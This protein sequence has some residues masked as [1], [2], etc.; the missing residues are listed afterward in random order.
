MRIEVVKGGA[1]DALRAA[2]SFQAEWRLLSDRCI[3]ATPFQSPAF[4]R[5]WYHIYRLRFE[6]V[7]VVSRDPEGRLSGLLPLACDLEDGALVAAGSHQAEYQTWICSPAD[8]G[9]F[10]L[11]CIKALRQHFPLATLKLRYLPPATP[12]DWLIAPAAKRACVADVQRRPLLR[13]NDGGEIEQSLSKSGNKSRLRQLKKIGAVEFR[14]IHQAAEFA[15]LVAEAAAFHDV[16]QQELRGS[17][18]FRNDPRKLPFHCAMLEQPGLLHVTVLKVGNMLASFH[19]NM[20]HRQGVQLGLIAHN[21]SLAR[22]SPGK[23]HI[24]MLGQMLR[25]Q[26]YCQ[27]DLTPGGEPYKERFAN[28]FDQV[29]TLAIYPT[30]VRRWMGLARHHAE[31]GAKR[32]LKAI[33]ASGA[34]SIK[35]APAAPTPA[36]NS[37]APKTRN[38]PAASQAWRGCPRQASTSPP[39]PYERPPT[40]PIEGAPPGKR[41]S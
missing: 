24:L 28:A 4:A 8:A 27:L 26:G 2:D 23:L 39:T 37:T 22:L 6:P 1:A 29:H 3:W 36:G 7:L 35:I 19:A 9:R 13:F 18:P 41:Q 32:F 25:E 33:R 30:P 17:A 34:P 5:T 38:R 40:H 31:A 21:P 15:A 14:Q 12:L 11:D 16:R 20:I 10:P